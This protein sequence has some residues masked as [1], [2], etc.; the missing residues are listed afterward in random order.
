MTTN[1]KSIVLLDNASKDPCGIRD[2]LRGIPLVH[3]EEQSATLSEINGH[4]LALASSHDMIVFRADSENG[5]DIAAVQL[6][7]R[8]TD[9]KAVLLAL[10]DESATLSFAQKLK[11]A[12]VN[13]VLPDTIG[14]K[15]LRGHIDRLICETPAES[16]LQLGAG[17]DRLGKVLAVAQARGGIGATTLAVNMSDWLLNRKGFGKKTASNRVVLVDL[18]VQFGAVASLLDLPGS[19]AF[20]QMAQDNIMPDETYVQQALATHSSGLRVLTAP[21]GFIPLDL[22]R[23][24]QISRLIELLRKDFDYVVIDLPRTLVDWVGGVI[25]LADRVFMVT[26]TSVPA[27]RNASRLIQLYTEDTLNL[28]VDVVVNYEKKPLLPHSHHK[29]AAKVLNRP[30]N[31][32]LPFDPKAAREASD[33][34]V[35]L[36]E[37]AA[38]SALAKAIDRLGRATLKGLAPQASTVVAK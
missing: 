25:E 37:A 29:Q 3:V 16:T 36:S 19:D 38:R 21:Q 23:R 4:A 18:D 6:I 13:E 33:R 34:G 28:N 27:I 24:D 9:G 20:E 17:A 5:N 2:V 15:D 30:L 32:W 11:A 10:T 22:L 8:Q 35:P 1:E 26:D 12:G 7:R 31:G 14:A